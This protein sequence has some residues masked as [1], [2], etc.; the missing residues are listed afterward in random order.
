M[1]TL[2]SKTDKLTADL[3]AKRV[4]TAAAQASVDAMV[5]LDPASPDDEALGNGEC[6]IDSSGGTVIASIN[7]KVATLKIKHVIN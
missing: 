2:K 5:T 1:P 3:A 6:V 4:A 7:G